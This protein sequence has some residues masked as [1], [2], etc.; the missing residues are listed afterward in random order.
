MNEQLLLVDLENIQRF[1]VGKAPPNAHI[2]IFV[3]QLQSK[4]PTALVQQAQASPAEPEPASD[5][6]WAR[7][8]HSAMSWSTPRH[9]AR[10]AVGWS[11]CGAKCL[12]SSRPVHDRHCRCPAGRP[13][14][15]LYRGLS[16]FHRR[17]VT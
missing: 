12:D 6:L 15:D 1:D 13:A 2:K 7:G 9:A 14:A 11:R 5:S 17:D 3:G 16:D 10:S 8:F 4:L